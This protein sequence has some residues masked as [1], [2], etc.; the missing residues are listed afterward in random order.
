MVGEKMAWKKAWKRT[1]S[2]KG[3]RKTVWE[4]VEA[5]RGVEG[6][7]GAAEQNREQLNTKKK[8]WGKNKTEKMTV[9]QKKE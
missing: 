6:Q 4:E 2:L 7:K 3:R 9:G 8:D 1:I 5:E